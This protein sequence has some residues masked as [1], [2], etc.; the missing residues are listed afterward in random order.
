MKQFLNYT[1]K[2]GR[3]FGPA[4]KQSPVYSIART[5]MAEGAAAFKKQIEICPHPTG[6]VNEKYWWEGWQHEQRK[7]SRVGPQIIE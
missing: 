5:S 2:R 3:Q 7:A 6:S 4:Q 1:T